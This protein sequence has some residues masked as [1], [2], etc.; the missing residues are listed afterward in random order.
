MS[1][2]YRHK[3]KPPAL[4]RDGRENRI[5]SLGIRR[6]GWIHSGQR[7]QTNI[8]E[9]Q[10]CCFYSEAQACRKAGE[11]VTSMLFFFFFCFESPSHTV[12]LNTLYFYERKPHI[13]VA[14]HKRSLFLMY[15]TSTQWSLGDQPQAVIRE[16]GL[17][18]ST[19]CNTRFPKVTLGTGRKPG[20]GRRA[21][22]GN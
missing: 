3:G 14:Q 19:I 6:G 20:D 10:S 18:E 17:I 8:C 1:K 7:D 4:L 2:A 15:V 9:E 5:W 12:F 16:S 13:S 22:V 21:S 11:I